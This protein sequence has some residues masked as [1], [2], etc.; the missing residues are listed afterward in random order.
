MQQLWRALFILLLIK[1]STGNFCSSFCCSI[2]R[3]R[4][5]Q[6]GESEKH[7]ESDELGWSPPSP[8]LRAFTSE[9]C[10]FLK[11]VKGAFKGKF[12]SE[13]N[14]LLPGDSPNYFNM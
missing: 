13:E 3:E 4:S 7:Q 2:L 6:I 9:Y 14:F 11:A 12:C 1:W 8:A 5:M 10:V